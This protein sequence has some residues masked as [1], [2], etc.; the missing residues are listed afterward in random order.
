[1]LYEE[2][3]EDTCVICGNPLDVVSIMLGNNICEECT[4]DNTDASE[5]TED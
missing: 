4:N 5:D 3:M 1:M 2:Y